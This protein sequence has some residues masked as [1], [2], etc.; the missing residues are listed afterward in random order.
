MCLAV[1][2][3]VVSVE[4]DQA[5]VALEGNTRTANLS[6]VGDAAVG[7]WVLLHA[8]FAIEKISSEEA[9]ETLGLLREVGEL[10]LETE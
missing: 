3:Q 1:P 7:E 8:G 2:V 10:S 5:T 4:G 6:L 9:Q